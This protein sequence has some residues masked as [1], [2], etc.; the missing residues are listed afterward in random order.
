MIRDRGIR[1]KYCQDFGVELV[2]VQYCGYA[3]YQSSENSY[4]ERC[5]NLFV[6]KDWTEI[7]R[8]H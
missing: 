1:E 6:S 4:S 3:K 2:L 8:V 5:C 7:M